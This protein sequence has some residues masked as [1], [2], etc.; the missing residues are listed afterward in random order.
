MFHITSYG[1][2]DVGLERTNNEDAFHISPLSGLYVVCDGM[3][4][5]ASGEMASAI[6]VESMVEFITETI[7]QD[8]FRWPFNSPAATSL[9][10][11]ILDCAVRIANRKVH[12][13]AQEDARHKGMGTTMVA[14]LAGEENMGIIHVGDSRIYRLRDGA[15]EQLTEDH[16]LLNHYLRTR[17]M[18]DEEIA[19]FKGKNVIVR[20]V[21]LRD[22][23]DPE[24]GM[25][26]Y[27]V[28]D[29]LLLCTDGLTDLVSDEEINAELSSA[30]SGDLKK[31]CHNLVQKALQAGG[32]DNVTV[33]V[34]QV[35]DTAGENQ[36]EQ[37]SS[38]DEDSSP[39]F[40]AADGG[41]WDMETQPGYDASTV[42]DG[43][44][45]SGKTDA[46]DSSEEEE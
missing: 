15:L 13:K 8:S 23:V 20:A 33:L 16:S 19:N 24:L 12:Q 27:Q 34:M 21:G 7:H 37:S 10:T 4:G 6:T 30:M 14:V 36:M 3:G 31:A 35:T 38:Q 9:E 42:D 39:G 45:L 5:H 1:I 22:A 44:L 28:G 18:S 26:D 41:Y 17:S 40:D 11:R 46:P 32:K 29:M 2:T 43:Q 25:V